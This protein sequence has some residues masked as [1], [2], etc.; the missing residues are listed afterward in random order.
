M[1]GRLAAGWILLFFSISCFQIFSRISRIFI[2]QAAAD[3]SAAAGSIMKFL[4]YRIPV[5]GPSRQRSIDRRLIYYAAAWRPPAAPPPP[6]RHRR[7]GRP[8]SHT[9]ARCAATLPAM[10]LMESAHGLGTGGAS[11]R[12][13]LPLLLLA[14]R[15]LLAG[16]QCS[17][18]D[19]GVAQTPPMGWV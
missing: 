3:Q 12:C 17:A 11:C 15:L 18:L 7:R 16:E 2:W 6:R 1:H 9:P 5:P 14:A 13:W 4:G 8:L 10:G 19:N